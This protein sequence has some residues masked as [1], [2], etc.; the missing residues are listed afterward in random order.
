MGKLGSCSDTATVR[1]RCST[2]CPTS[3]V[4]LADVVYNEASMG[5]SLLQSLSANA[6]D[7]FEGASRFFDN[8]EKPG[9]GTHGDLNNVGGGRRLELRPA[10]RMTNTVVFVCDERT[11]GIEFRFP[12][13]DPPL[14]DGLG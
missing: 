5:W 10:E 1:P 4:P 2:R 6:V 14:N 3:A 13:S 12:T 9:M 11:V 7:A 8:T